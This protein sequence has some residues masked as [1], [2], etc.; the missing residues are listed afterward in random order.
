MPIDVEPLHDAA[1][2]AG[3]VGLFVV[4]RAFSSGATA[5][6]GVE[7]ISNG[8]PAFRHPQARNAADTLAIM[9]AIAIAMFMGISWLST[10]VEGV[11]ASE[12][13]S[14][15]AQI[16]LAVFGAGSVGFFVVQAFTAAILILAAN[17]AYQDFPRLA[18]ILARDRYMPSQFVNRGD[19]LVFSNGVIVLGGLASLMIYL[20]D[21]D[22][23]ALIHLYVVG[24]FTSFT[25]SQ[26]GH[27]QALDRGRAQ[28]RGSDARVAPV[29][30]D[31][32][33]RR[34]RDR[35]RARRRGRLEVRRAARGSRS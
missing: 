31:Q 34:D 29:H 22:L 15:V 3:A 17:T 9:G 12:E 26:T 27:G 16:A 1:T 13:R 32:H 14:I 4:L 21:A 25:L 20:F 18:S 33:R 28:G 7:A 19:R 5:L 11:I 6:T 35:G 2:A 24:V 23:N 8:V 30:R 10:H